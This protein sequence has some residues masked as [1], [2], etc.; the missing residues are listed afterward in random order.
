MICSIREAREE[1]AH[2]VMDIDLKCFTYPWSAEF[3]A[4]QEDFYKTLVATWYG[5]PVAM[6]VYSV[7]SVI[8]PTFCY[9]AD[10]GDFTI[11]KVGVKKNYRNKGIGR[12]LVNHIK[13]VADGVKATSVLAISPESSCLPPGNNAGS[14]MRKLGF[15]GKG[16]IPGCF[17]DCGDAED[18]YLFELPLRETP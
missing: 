9:D 13:R 11:L 14:W 8:C 17:I 16:I 4:D 3:W 12:H 18:G 1:D 15:K 7:G 2:Y 10:D 5:T 6:A